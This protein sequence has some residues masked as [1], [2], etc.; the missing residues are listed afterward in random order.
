MN[1][2][3]EKF[4]A[5]AIQRSAL[6]GILSLLLTTSLLSQAVPYARVFPKSA[7]EVETALKELQAYSGEKLPI[8]DGFVITGEKPLTQY[9]RA[10][11]QFSIDLLPGQT[12]GTIV[13]VT[14]KIT[15]WYVDPAPWKS[16]YQI[17]P[18]MDVLSWIC[19][20]GSAK[21]R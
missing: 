19:L 13:R 21:V 14:A 7:E 11:Y 12:G 17:L 2:P 8:V 16:G 5:S 3:Q 1:R 18:S 10:F 15:A 20:I 9:E 6:G 4:L